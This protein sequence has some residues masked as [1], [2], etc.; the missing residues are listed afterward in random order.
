MQEPRVNQGL[1]RYIT[2]NYTGKAVEVG[3]GRRPETAAALSRNSFTVVCTDVEPRDTPEDVEFH[4][5]D[6]RDPDL[7]IYRDADVVYSLRP[8]YELHHALADVAAAAHADLLLK[9]LGSEGTPLDHELVNAE[10]EA[11]YLVEHG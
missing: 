9:P 3:V 10:G 11:L 2:S 7:D 1:L 6:V 8:P 5:D 4:V